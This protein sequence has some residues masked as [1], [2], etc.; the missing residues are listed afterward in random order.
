MPS[1]GL[2]AGLSGGG[3][4]PRLIHI[5]YTSDYSS[6]RDGWS[7]S[8]DDPEVVPAGNQKVDGV[9][10]CLTITF[11]TDV[12]ITITKTL[13]VGTDDDNKGY[14]FSADVYVSSSTRTGDLTLFFGGFAQNTT[15]IA[16]NNEEWTP[17]TVAGTFGVV[18]GSSFG[19]NVASADGFSSGD[20]I[21][22]KNV[23][24]TIYDD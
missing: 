11:G 19:F 8:N 2:G 10:E 22:L 1:L 3:V 4:K 24:L 16:I 9:E 17:V 12:A 23:S 6:D 20:V 7:V 21:A 18:S 15:D 13:I 5:A 14:A